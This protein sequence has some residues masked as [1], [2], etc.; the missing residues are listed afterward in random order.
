[1]LQLVLTACLLAV[2]KAGI[3]APAASIAYAPAAVKAVDA[4][5]DPHPQYSYAYDVQ[6]S[7]TNDFKSQHET[8]DGDSVQG[9]YS[10]LEADGTRR[11]VDYTAD[12]I[13]GFNAVV[14]KEP[15]SQIAV[16]TIAKIATPLAYAAPVAKIA[17]PLAYGAAPAPIS[18]ARPASLVYPGPTIQ[19]AP[20]AT[21]GVPEYY[22]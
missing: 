8:R 17:A 1:M 15:G 22:H 2:V 19:A 7:L 13:N 21:Y 11:I 3:L 14:R 10:L 18:V 12:P 6:D 5:Y 20:V 4:D 9:S 16:K